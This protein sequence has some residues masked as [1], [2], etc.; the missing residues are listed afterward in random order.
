MKI[1]KKYYDFILDDSKVDMLEGTTFSGKTTT[2]INTKFLYK[3]KTTKRNK[4]L[5]ASESL[6]VLVSNI[7]STGDCGLLDNYPEIELYLNGSNEQKL[8]HLKIDDNIV[9]LVGYSDIARFKKVLGGQFG[10][11]FIDEINIADMSFVRELFLPRFEY[12]CGTLNPDNPD[13][14]IYSDIINRCRPLE[15]YKNDV[16]TEIME[17]LNKSIE[18]KDWRYW[19]FTFDD[20]PIITEELKNELLS[21]LLPDTLEYQTKIAGKRSKGTGQIMP[22]TKDNIITEE[23][24]IYIGIDG[25]GDKIRR[26]WK[27]FSFAVDTKYSVKSNDVF[28]MVFD[29]IDSNGKLI[30]LEEKGFNNKGLKEPLSPSDM[31]IQIDEFFTYCCNKWGITNTI[32]IDSEDAGTISEMQKFRREKGRSYNIVGSWKK[33]KILD[34]VN[35]QNGWIKALN[36]LIVDHCTNIINEH[37]N[38]CYDKDGKIPETDTPD[39]FINADQYSW[40]PYKHEIGV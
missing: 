16:P 22:I 32:F 2:A 7:L 36:Y 23:N 31:V 28:A 33:L 29:G 18:H 8:P 15:K 38:Y 37:N 26:K 5:I 17:E 27:R 10:A 21:S 6:G 20:N 13:K 30:T 19:Y 3:V 25:N 24:A 34:R 14:E 12:C 40:I 9:Y 35:L 4:H 11:V 1:S 39:H